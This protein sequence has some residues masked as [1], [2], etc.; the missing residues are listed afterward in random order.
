MADR[1]LRRALGAALL[2]LPFAGRPAAASPAPEALLEAVLRPPRCAYSGLLMVTHWHG[3]RAAAEEVRVSFSPPNRYRWEFLD[4]D[5]KVDRIAIS[6]GEVEWV[7]LP[8][9]RRL[10]KGLAIKSSEKLMD[11]DRE[12]ETLLKN[13]R[14]SVSGSEQLFGRTVWVLDFKPVT[15][16]KPRQT[17]WIDPASGVV[18]EAKRS[19]RQTRKSGSMAVYSRF[20]RFDAGTKVSDDL[21]APPPAAGRRVDEYGLDPDFMSLDELAKATGRNWGYPGELP[22]GFVFE[23][24]DFFRV[25]KALVEHVRYTDGLAVLSLFATDK[26]VR[27]PKT[28]GPASRQEDFVPDAFRLTLGPRVMAWKAGRRHYTL[29][30]DVSRD[31]LRAISAHFH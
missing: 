27:P 15:S 5:G 29:V 13:Y 6:D 19:L 16:G 1:S 10:L 22:E 20:T 17:F 31:L 26:P 11:E 14:L 18:L 21:F 23:S 12:K 8:A 7:D 9:Q 3:R 28:G 25:R 2:A 24:A 4:P 30:G